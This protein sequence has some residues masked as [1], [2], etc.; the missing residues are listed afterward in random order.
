MEILDAIRQRR[1]IRRYDPRPIEGEKVEAL[2]Q[3]MEECNREGGLRI[4]LVTDDPAAFDGRLA[5]YGKFRDV[6][7]YFALVG[8]K[9]PDLE[10]RAGYYGERLVL[11]AEQ[12]GLATCW[13]ALTY[14]KKKARVEVAEGEARVCVISLG[15]AAEA[16]HRHKSKTF[17]QVVLPPHPADRPLAEDYPDWF[18]RGVEAALYAPTAINQQQFRFRLCGS[19]GVEATTRWGF[20][21]KVDLGIAKLHFELGAGRENFRWC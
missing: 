17:E 2:R 19:D 18:R 6:R 4:Q 10:E 3:L 11:R 8:R 21:A 16:A 20:Y 5:H 13:V 1:S 14:S 15:Y 12:L 9:A 7:N